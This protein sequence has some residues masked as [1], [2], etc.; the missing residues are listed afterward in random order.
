MANQVRERLHGNKTFFN[1]NRHINPT[2][3]CVASCK[4]CAFGKKAKDPTAYAFSLEEIWE[5]AGRGHAEGVT[6]FHIVGGLHPG[7]FAR[8]VLRDA[9]RAEAALPGSASE[10]LHDGRDRLLRA[11]HEDQPPRSAGAAEGCRAWIRCPA[12]ARRFSRSACGASSAITSCRAISGLRSRAP[13]IRW[14]IHSN[15]TML[16]GHIE[17]EEDRV[18]H[19]LRLRGLQDDTARLPDFHSAGVPSGQY[20][21]GAHW[22]DHRL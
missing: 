8:L 5:R 11:A 3:V 7:A 9:A 1:V 14:G 12:A 13:L 18:D 22:Q 20:R 2:D 4:L 16:Y 6:E 15:C 10:G 19:L 17:T 21:N